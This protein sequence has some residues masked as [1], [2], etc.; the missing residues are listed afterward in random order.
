MMASTNTDMN[1][2]D[3]RFGDDFEHELRETKLS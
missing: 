3:S 1:E 2:R